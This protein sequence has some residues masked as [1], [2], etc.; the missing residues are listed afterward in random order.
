MIFLWH[1][2][3]LERCMTT[4]H[5][6][7]TS[8]RAANFSFGVICSGIVIAQSTGNAFGVKAGVS[9]SNLRADGEDVSDEN[10]RTAFHAG[11]FGRISASEALGVQVELLYSGKGTTVVYD[12]LIDQ[13]T[14]FKLSY[15]E[16]PVF[17]T[18]G[19]G[20]AL[21]IHA[22]VYA[23]Y[24]MSSNVTTE[25]DLGSGSDDIDRDNFQ[26]ADYGLLGGLGVNFGPAQVGARYVHGLAKLAATDEAEF[27]L[28]SAQ[29]STIQVY[30]AIGLQG[31]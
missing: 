5:L 31:Q 9:F 2:I 26:G 4:N 1:G 23:A 22:G 20:D 25:G 19:L 12:G 18:I 15:L 7:C 17:A 16:V 30:L 21:E 14:T 27:L 29:N 8:L 11:I 10:M 13:E 28:G 24:L 3:A 6:L